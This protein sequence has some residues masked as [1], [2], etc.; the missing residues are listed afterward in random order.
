[1]SAHGAAPGARDSGAAEIS[2]GNA[3]DLTPREP[4]QHHLPAA[5]KAVP[6]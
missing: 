1:V 5:T 2:T 6:A 4:L 3:V